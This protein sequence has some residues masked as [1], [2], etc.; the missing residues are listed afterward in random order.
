MTETRQVSNSGL[1]LFM[2]ALALAAT[3]PTV[4]SAQLLPDDRATVWNPGIPGGI[5]LRTTV[6][7]TINAAAYGNGSVDATAGIQSAIN[8]CPEG[9]VVQLSDGTFK[10]SADP[11]RL[12]KGVTLRGAGPTRTTL[13]KPAGTNLA[14]VVIG[15]QWDTES[16][17]TNFTSNGL[18][19]SRSV[20]VASS[21]GLAI[22]QVVLIDKLTD[23][24]ISYWGARHDPPGG[25]SR[26][27][28]VR[29]DRPLTQMMEIAG[30]SGNTITFT[31]PFHI[32]FDTAHSAQLTYFPRNPVKYAGVEDLKLYGGGGGDGGGNLYMELAAYSWAKN[33]ESTWTI[34]A[35]G[36]MY[37]CFRCV[38]RDSYFHDTPDANPG[39]AGYG[40]D[41]SKATSDSL[42]EN[43]ISVR[44]NKTLLMRAAGGGNVIAYNYFE[45]GYGAGYKS[46]PEIGLNAAHYTT[47]HHVLFEGNQAWN[48]ASETYW[49]NSAYI[50]FFRNH[51]TTKRRDTGNLGLTDAVLRRGVEIH[52]KSFWYTFIGN[53]I[54]YSGMTPSP[55]SSFTYEDTYPFG[56]DPVP[57]WRIGVPDQGTPEVTTFDSQVTATLIRDGNF[58]YV[59]NTV[60]WDRPAQTIPSSLYLTS[61]PAFFGTCAWPWVDPLGTSKVNVLPARARFDGNATACGATPTP[62]PAP[63]NARLTP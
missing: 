2:A 41:I 29:Q 6:C 63:N 62:L 13:T 16:G 23:D 60:K 10:I 37:R 3:L 46:I 61:K 53:V 22:G 49:G 33:I 43:N 39:G 35:S 5:P 4:S 58:D 26:R 38:I 25:G 36:R 18:K 9:Q 8:S 21:A 19:G 40:L 45:D 42:V 34:G 24:S 50:T 55:F 48:I 20:T 1:R 14:T 32:T 44:F 59:T 57:M 31:T 30:I 12:T 28:F 51:A 56:D 54:G 52:A 15:W 47:S 27:W 7:A 17:S 11:I